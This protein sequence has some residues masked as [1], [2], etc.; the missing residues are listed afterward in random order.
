MQLHHRYTEIVRTTVNLSDAL[1]AA[2]QK[3][4]AQR[5]VRFS[6]I[7]EEA[8]QSHLSAKAPRSAA[9]FRLHT[10]RGRLVDPN[11]DLD[12]TSALLVAD[13]ELAFSRRRR[14]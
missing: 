11:L 12:R 10:V 1:L 7:V 14:R 2:T 6:V 5:G 3:R 4:A 8:L 9:P 13:D